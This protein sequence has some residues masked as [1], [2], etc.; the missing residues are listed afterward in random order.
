MW[1]DL[2]HC[3][4]SC[5]QIALLLNLCFVYLS[6]LQLVC[7]GGI[8]LEHCVITQ[9]R[10]ALVSFLYSWHSELIYGHA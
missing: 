6:G 1:S 8:R 3:K 9:E 5:Y 10:L 4:C 7:L 2:G